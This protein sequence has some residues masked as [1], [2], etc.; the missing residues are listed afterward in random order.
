[1]ISCKMIQVSKNC[2]QLGDIGYILC[3]AMCC[4]P[5]NILYA[6]ALLDTMPVLIVDC[7]PRQ[8]KSGRTWR[9]DVQDHW[10]YAGN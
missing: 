1:M 3:N 6:V 7:G 2:F 5:S 9:R 4:T 8:L 10:S